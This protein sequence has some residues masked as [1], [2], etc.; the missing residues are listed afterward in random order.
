ML[1]RIGLAQAVMGEPD[2]LILDEVTSGLDPIGRRDLR[3]ILQDFKNRGK[4]VFFSSHELSEVSKICDRIILINEGKVVQE[5]SLQAIL[6]SRMTYRVRVEADDAL[7]AS[8][9]EMNTTRIAESVYEIKTGSRESYLKAL[10]RI[11]QSG[12][13]IIEV[14]SMEPSLEDYF[15]EVIGHKVA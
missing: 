1:Q 6:E 3:E 11:Q 13:R 9:C 7:P 4:T 15:V 10:E 8:L 12:I 14:E 5:R 2:L